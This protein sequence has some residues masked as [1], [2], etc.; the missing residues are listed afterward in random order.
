MTVM[1]KPELIPLLEELVNIGANYKIEEL[2]AIRKRFFNY[3]SEEGRMLR[4]FDNPE[5][6]VH[7][8]DAIN[9]I[10]AN[11][12]LH[13]TGSPEQANVFSQSVLDRLETL[14]ASNRKEN[15]WTYYD[16]VFY[17]GLCISAVD[18]KQLVL[19][20]DH[21]RLKLEELGD[22]LLMAKLMTNYSTRLLIALFWDFEKDSETDSLEDQNLEKMVKNTLSTTL[23]E[24]IT[25][26]KKHDFTD[27]LYRS[28]IMLGLFENDQALII[29]YFKKLKAI[30]PEYGSQALAKEISDYQQS[31]R[32]KGERGGVY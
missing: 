5:E 15:R 26:C 31:P 7:A 6:Y 3:L 11:L 4:V 23:Q 20:H 1:V 18:M 9:F 30:L 21:A 8:R 10:D 32:Y 29:K 13:R 24:T 14:R 17:T 19:M 22:P 25:F 27:F 12:I 16:I 28:K 2:L